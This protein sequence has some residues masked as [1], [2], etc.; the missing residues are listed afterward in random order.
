MDIFNE[1]NVLVIARTTNDHARIAF[2]EAIAPELKAL[3]IKEKLPRVLKRLQKY[4]P[5][6]KL[7]KKGLR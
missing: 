2:E 6:A 7:R 5:I 1:K 3:G 4:T